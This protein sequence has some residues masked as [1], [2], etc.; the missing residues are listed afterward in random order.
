MAILDFEKAFDNVTH[1]AIINCLRDLDFPDGLVNYLAFVYK[2]SMLSFKGVENTP[3]HP[4]NG[5]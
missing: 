2:D 1:S 5:V 3:I 4:I